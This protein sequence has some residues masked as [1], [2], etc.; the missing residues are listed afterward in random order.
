LY[1]C[2]AKGG[3]MPLKIIK[4]T[5][6]QCFMDKKSLEKIGKKLGYKYIR[7]AVPFKISCLVHKE[8]I[9]LVKSLLADKLSLD[10][11]EAAIKYRIVCNNVEI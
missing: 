10:I 7:Y 8:E 3:N 11:Y 5:D 6:N 9:D 4:M 1:L 2:S